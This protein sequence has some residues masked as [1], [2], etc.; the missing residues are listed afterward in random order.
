MDKKARLYMSLGVLALTVMVWFFVMQLRLFDSPEPTQ[1]PNGALFSG[2]VNS[3]AINSFG[4]NLDTINSDSADSTDSYGNDSKS[5]FDV[6][7]GNEASA[8]SSDE[9]VLT[10]D[11][12]ELLPTSSELPSDEDDPLDEIRTITFESG[13]LGVKFRIAD[14]PV[15]NFRPAER[16]SV[17]FP[18]LLSNHWW[19]EDLRYWT[20]AFDIAMDTTHPSGWQDVY[21]FEDTSLGRFFWEQPDIPKEVFVNSHGL[22]VVT[23]THTWEDWFGF[24]YATVIFVFRRDGQDYRE[25]SGTQEFFL[26][27][28][29]SPSELFEEAFEAAR[30]VVDSLQFLEG[31]TISLSPS[32]MARSLGVSPHDFPRIDGSTAAIPLMQTLI[33]TLF[34]PV[35]FPGATEPNWF[36]YEP[37]RVSGS[38][39][40]YELLIAEY[41]D[42]ILVPAPSTYI[43]ELAE[44]ADVELEFHP[45]TQ[46]AAHYYAVIRADTPRNSSTVTIIKWLLTPDGQAAVYTGGLGVLE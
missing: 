18:L 3:Y 8:G 22:T 7:Q 34:D 27:V 26:A 46:E 14:L 32:R 36:G 35:K 45:I 38:I 29:E 44:S 42:L 6:A 13:T 11:D 5:E 17:H 10:G 33:R 2:V 25:V 39:L 1:Y 16:S 19:L 15:W 40:A 23:Y 31:A 12:N 41:V 9:T 43:L 37:Q 20:M 30:A 21:D 4:I 24:P 28:L